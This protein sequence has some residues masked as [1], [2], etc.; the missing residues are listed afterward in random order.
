LHALGLSA[1]A[2]PL[3]GKRTGNYQKKGENRQSLDSN[4]KDS[5][6]CR[7]RWHGRKA[8]ALLRLSPS[9]M[10]ES[11][12]NVF[13][14][15]VTVVFGLLW[16]WIYNRIGAGLEY[17]MILGSVLAVCACCCKGG[18]PQREWS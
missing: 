12:I 15:V 17:L 13:R 5:I 16:W 1:G 2:R 9:H 10:G 7:P 6:Y 11:M 3:R 4:A 18:E 8:S 14:L